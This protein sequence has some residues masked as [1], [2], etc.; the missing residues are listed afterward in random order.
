MF[1]GWYYSPPSVFLERTPG[2]GPAQCPW[3]SLRWGW[4]VCNETNRNPIANRIF[5]LNIV[6][7][8]MHTPIAPHELAASRTM[9]DEHGRDVYVCVS[10]Y[11]SVMWV[12]F[13]APT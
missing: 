13:M 9:L 6:D 3:P 12:L 11:V 10:V 4:L 5:I 2:P 1:F 8:N 7:Q